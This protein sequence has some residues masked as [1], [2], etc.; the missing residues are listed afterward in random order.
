MDEDKKNGKSKPVEFGSPVQTRLSHRGS[1]IAGF[2]VA[3]ALLNEN[4]N[5]TKEQAVNELI[6]IG[7]RASIPNLVP[8]PSDIAVDSHFP[9]PPSLSET[10]TSSKRPATKAA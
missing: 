9:L 1:R 6:E 10:E 4:R 5:I 3:N 7:A 2:Y 8:D